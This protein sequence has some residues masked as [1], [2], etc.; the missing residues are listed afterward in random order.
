[1][2]IVAGLGGMRD[3]DGVISFAPRLPSAISRLTFRMAV[4]GRRLVVDVEPNQATY[5]LLLG[6][7]L[8]IVHYGQAGTVHEGRPLTLAIAPPPVLET[9]TQPR[10]RAPARRHIS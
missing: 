2:G 3:H 8:E 10:G 7:A 1:M 6:D 4:R 5:S 9:P